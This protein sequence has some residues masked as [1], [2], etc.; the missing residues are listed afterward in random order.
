M[1]ILWILPISS[2]EDRFV[3]KSEGMGFSPMIMHTILCRGALISVHFRKPFL[4]CVFV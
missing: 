2:H 4:D 3:K 1:E